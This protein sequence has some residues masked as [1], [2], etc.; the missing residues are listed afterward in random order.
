MYHYH[1]C[2]TTGGPSSLS[3][4]FSY[5]RSCNCLSV[6]R[7]PLSSNGDRY[8]L[9]GHRVVVVISRSK[10]GPSYHCVDMIGYFTRIHDRI[11]TSSDEWVN[12]T[13]NPEAFWSVFY[14]SQV[15]R[16][17][18]STYIS[19]KYARTTPN[20]IPTP[21]MFRTNMISLVVFSYVRGIDGST[22]D[23]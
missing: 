19:S 7:P 1:F 21:N 5:W 6:Q 3:Y 15:Y 4:H 18:A 11:E 10:V 8:P 2:D 20:I 9:A 16:D 23:P 14:P 22:R 13:D 17:D 12:V